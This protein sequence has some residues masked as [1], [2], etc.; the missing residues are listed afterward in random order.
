MASR[1]EP[2]TEIIPLRAHGERQAETRVLASLPLRIGRERVEL[3]AAGIV[4]TVVVG[5]ISERAVDATTAVRATWS[6]KRPRRTSDRQAFINWV[7]AE[8]LVGVDFL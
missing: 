8:V 3:V 1:P 2:G 5:A 7:E 6:R 4:V